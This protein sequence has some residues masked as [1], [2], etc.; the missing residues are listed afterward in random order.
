MGGRLLLLALSAAAAYAAAVT[1]PNMP[2]II[3]RS[4]ENVQADWSQAPKYSFVERD[5]ESKR[6]SKPAIRSYEEIMIDGSPYRRL[7]AVDDEPISPGEQAEEERKLR[8]EIQKRQNESDRER[9]KRVE[10]YLRERHQDHAMLDALANAFDFQAAGH[11]IVD[12]HDCWVFDATP[13]PG[14]K[15]ANR[16][17]KV[18]IGMK[19][20]LWVDKSSDQWVK[21]EAEVIKPV[22]LFGFVARIGPGTRFL[23]EQAP[24]AGNLWLPKHFSMRVN[25]SV[26]GFINEDSVD[27]ETY[28]DYQPMS[29]TSA[30]LQTH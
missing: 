16:E 9:S 7:I 19:G 22:S 8:T 18:L 12:G 4:V 11:E 14:Y 30:E 26:L 1:A 3:R 5:V 13:K 28:R 29:R 25:A 21:V 6:R 23:L 24:V 15:P 20:R 10:R 2:E 27:D 17:T